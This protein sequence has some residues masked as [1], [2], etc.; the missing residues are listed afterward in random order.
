MLIKLK[1]RGGKRNDSDFGVV[2]CLSGFW[3]LNEWRICAHFMNE[4][5]RLLL[6][7]PSVLIHSY[8]SSPSME[9]TKCKNTLALK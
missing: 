1:Y 8:E 5:G 2:S 6:N 3:L 9:K 4:N 7:W